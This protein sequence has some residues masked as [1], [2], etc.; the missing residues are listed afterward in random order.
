ML[1]NK[2]WPKGPNPRQ[3]GFVAPE[4]CTTDELD[5]SYTFYKPVSPVYQPDGEEEANGWHVNWGV[6]QSLQQLKLPKT[7]LENIAPK[8]EI[9]PALL[10]L[11]P[12]LKCLGEWHCNAMEEHL[13]PLRPSF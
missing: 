8:I 7:L 3:A 5:G 11:F 6:M 9:I 13:V 2:A 12:N 4:D 1:K 10:A